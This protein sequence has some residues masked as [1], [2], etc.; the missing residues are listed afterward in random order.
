[1][2][3]LPP[4]GRHPIRESATLGWYILRRHL[5]SIKVGERVFNP[6]FA[7]QVF[8]LGNIYLDNVCPVPII[9]LG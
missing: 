1:M 3:S 4:S 8:R 9:I 6:D 2:A 7:E 5:L